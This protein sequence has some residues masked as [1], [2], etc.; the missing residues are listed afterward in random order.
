MV[1][2]SCLSKI[3]CSP[4]H[5]LVNLGTVLYRGEGFVQRCENPF[6][7]NGS[8]N[9][10]PIHVG[11]KVRADPSEDD[12]DASRLKFINQIAN[13]LRSRIVDIRYGARIDNKPADRRRRAGN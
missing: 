5:S 13:R 1:G 3:S 6:L 11:L 12:L 7:A 9:S 2:W 4:V 10:V 8:C